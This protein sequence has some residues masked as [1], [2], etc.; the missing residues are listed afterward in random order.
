[1]RVEYLEED[2]TGL[3]STRGRSGRRFGDEKSKDTVQTTDNC[4][5]NISLGGSKYRRQ[6]ASFSSQP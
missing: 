2:C 1:M 5:V 4:G 3:M 6:A